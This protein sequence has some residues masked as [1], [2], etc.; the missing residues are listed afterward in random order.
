MKPRIDSERQQMLPEAE[1]DLSGVTSERDVHEAFARSLHF[2]DFYGHNWDAF[3]D[4]LCCFDVFPP[5]LILS[6]RDH[7]HAVVPRALEMLDTAFADCRLEH[8]DVARDVIWR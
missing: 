8:S 5:R 6:G 3:W 2:P 7:V 4:V 1:I